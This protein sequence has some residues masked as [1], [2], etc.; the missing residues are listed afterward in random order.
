MDEESILTCQLHPLLREIFT[1]LRLM[2]EPKITNNH[3]KILCKL[4]PNLH[5]ILKIMV[6]FVSNIN[7]KYCRKQ[8]I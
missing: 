7:V 1:S 4:E 2:A 8:E 6:Q 5:Q 3:H